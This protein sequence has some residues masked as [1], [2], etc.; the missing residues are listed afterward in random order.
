[1][2]DWGVAKLKKCPNTIPII[3]KNR[4]ESNAT[5]RIFFVEGVAVDDDDDDDDMARAVDDVLPPPPRW[6]VGCNNDKNDVVV[7]VGIV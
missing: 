3:N 4:I 6:I 5:I 7:V 1:M 2:T